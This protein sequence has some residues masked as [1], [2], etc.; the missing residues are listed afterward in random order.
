MS[1]DISQTV[2]AIQG[3]AI[4]SVAPQDG[5]ILVWDAAD[6]YWRPQPQQ[7]SKQLQTQTFTSNGTWTAPIFI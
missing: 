5:Y 2:I 6:G 7:A 3:E 4:S 1:S